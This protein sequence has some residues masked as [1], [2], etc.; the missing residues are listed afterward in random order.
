[1]Q[2]AYRCRSHKVGSIKAW[3]A[4][5]SPFAGNSPRPVSF[6]SLRDS[7]KNYTAGIA[8]YPSETLT[9]IDAGGMPTNRCS[10][11]SSHEETATTVGS[12]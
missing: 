8:D 6:I 10:R 2:G 4:V 7:R 12:I 3:G 5:V 1:M 11:S 9:R